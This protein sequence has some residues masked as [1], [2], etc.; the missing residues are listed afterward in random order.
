V[1]SLRNPKPDAIDVRLWIVD[2]DE[3][4]LNVE[5]GGLGTS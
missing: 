5:A 2:A 4:K 1:T 3:E